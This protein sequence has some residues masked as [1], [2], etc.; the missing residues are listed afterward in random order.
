MNKLAMILV[1]AVAFS[2][3]PAAAPEQ[4][5]VTVQARSE[6][7]ETWGHQ[8]ILVGAGF[9][10]KILKKIKKGL[11]KIVSSAKKLVKKVI[12]SPI[13]KIALVAAAIYTG[14]AALAAF[15]AG[16]GMAGFAGNMAAIGTQAGWGAAMGGYK[17]AAG[18]V[19]SKVRSVIGGGGQ[20]GG[21]TLQQGLREGT[22]G[23]TLQQGLREGT[24]T[25][26]E[27]FP[28]AFGSKAAA[29]AG[30]GAKAGGIKGIVGSAIGFAKNNPLLA[31]AGATAA[32]GMMS[33][34]SAQQDAE[35]Q[36]DKKSR[37]WGR[38]DSYYREHFGDYYKSPR[39]E[40]ATAVA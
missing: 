39:K 7:T 14:G 22:Y 16:S 25:A 29:A 34:Y 33:A 37:D 35:K 18:G 36:R 19:W 10:G 4:H 23:G 38:I 32:G 3:A 24:L 9:L 20:A 27:M 40:T 28:A 2:A 30:A 5:A 17:T 15:Q 1:A 8:M 31:V 26:T 12:K 6:Q 21:G 13:G 11:K